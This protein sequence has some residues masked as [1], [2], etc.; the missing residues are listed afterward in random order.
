VFNALITLLL[1]G[2]VG[3]VLASS[4]PT[5]FRMT[6]VA[7]YIAWVSAMALWVY[8]AYRK[9][10]RGLAYGPNEYVEESRLAYEHKLALAKLSAHRKSKESGL[11]HLFS[12]ASRTTRS[13]FWLVSR[14]MH[15]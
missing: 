10:P 13:A 15:L 1:T 6:I 12:V 3:G 9:D 7:V 2:I 11:A 14:G 8:K 5:W 4:L